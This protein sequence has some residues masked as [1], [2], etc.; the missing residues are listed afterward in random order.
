MQLSTSQINISA[1]ELSL[2]FLLICFFSLLPEMIHT[3]PDKGFTEYPKHLE[4]RHLLCEVY[5]FLD[6]ED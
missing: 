3:C 1:V 6:K 5:S 4:S 2:S